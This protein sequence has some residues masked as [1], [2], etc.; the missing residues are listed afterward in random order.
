MQAFCQHWKER[1]TDNY[2]VL[3]YIWV[4]VE[5]ANERIFL[6]CQMQTGDFSFGARIGVEDA[7]SLDLLQD[8]S[9][10]VQTC[11]SV[12]AFKLMHSAHR[13]MQWQKLAER[14]KSRKSQTHHSEYSF[15]QRK[16]K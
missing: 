2:H 12:F 14:K 16:S 3:F 6:W 7:K 8:F 9:L 1:L 11:L 13:E 15:L 4:E 5:D 10:S